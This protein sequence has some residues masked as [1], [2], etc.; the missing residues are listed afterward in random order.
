[1]NLPFKE[2]IMSSTG[3]LY[4]LLFA[5]QNTTYNSQNFTREKTHGLGLA[6]YKFK[7]SESF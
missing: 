7:A 5:Q 3:F 1:M 4:L 2:K 6:K